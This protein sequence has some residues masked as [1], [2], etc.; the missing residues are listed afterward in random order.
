MERCNI[1]KTITELFNGQ[2]SYIVPLYQRN[3][4]WGEVEI[5][6]L[7]QDLYENFKSKTSYFVGSIIYLNRDV[8]GGKLEVIDGQQRLTVL[9]L[10][11]NVLGKDLLPELFASRLEYDSRDEVTAYLKGLYSSEE[12][13]T[14]STDV[15]EIIKTF[16]VAYATLENC[17]LNPEDE[18][19]SIKYLKEKDPEQLQFFAEY[20]S[21]QVYFVLAEMPQDTDVATYFEIMNNTGDQLRKHEIAKSLVL[22][23]AKAKNATL[24]EMKSLAMIW[25]ACSQMNT[26][27]QETI[28]AAKRSMIFGD[29]YESFF[30][31]NITK[32]SDFI[33]LKEEKNTGTLDAIIGNV[34]YNK[35][36]VTIAEKDDNVENEVAVIDFPN[37]LMHVLRLCYNDIYKEKCE[38]NDIPLNEK[39]L[40]SVFY[41][42]KKDIDSKQFIAQ[43]LYYRII[44]DRYM[45]RI[46]ESSSEGKWELA[47]LKKSSESNGVYP[48]NTFGKETSDDVDKANKK[49]IQALSMLQVSYPQRKYKRF[50]NEILSWFRYGIVEYDYNWFMPKL[51]GLIL[52]LI[53]DIKDEYGDDLFCLGTNTPRFIL[54]VIDYLYYL[55]DKG[56]SFDFKYYNSV[57]HHLP[58]SREDYSK[59]ERN[60]LDSIGNLFLLSRRANSSLND[61]DPLAKAD[62]SKLII[63]TFPPNRKYIYQKTIKNRR[64][65]AEDIKKHEEQIRELLSRKEEILKIKELEEGPLLYR[66]CLAVADYCDK[67][68]GGSKYGRKYNFMDLSSENGVFAKQTVVS[69]Q[70]SHFDKS[71]E[72]FIEEQ[73]QT[74]QELMND[75]WRWCFVKYPSI[76][77]FCQ[78]GKFIWNKGG[79]EIYLLPHNQ[80]INN[81]R[82]L[83]CHLFVEKS[84]LESPEISINQYGVWIML[85]NANLRRSYPHANMSL[86]L[87]VCADCS[88]WCY[89]ISSSRAGNAK[90]NI[91][92]VKNGWVKNTEGRY[93]LLNRPYLCDCP[94]NYEVA[95]ELALSC[96][97]DIINEI[98]RMK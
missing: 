36:E 85:E 49:A 54:N 42:I 79:L 76:I 78:D 83:H 14:E 64:W 33:E 22:G 57:E 51:N 9:T 47:Y 19:V 84:G 62:K 17:P 82:E 2:Y 48:C 81:A 75:L 45:V 60:I 67:D 86:H 56:D 55:E 59:I 25:D 80:V 50:L 3:F 43:L 91:A 66:A 68:Y 28:P 88:K 92:L 58:Q 71:L 24:P 6:Q 73:L 97:Q 39:D 46:D 13:A 21:M 63:D 90:E 44:F 4:A 74:S 69:W 20:I 41:L 94:E 16:Q 26:R 40:L 29:N 7:L 61:S 98:N 96:Y 89:E 27:I 38:G 1:H 87:W 37:F 34:E 31:D 95:V 15:S 11:L 10:L 65:D 35:P 72:A 77:D 5:T 70:N 8:S 18:K 53:N 23:W 12:M 52:S 93:N 30:P 32:L